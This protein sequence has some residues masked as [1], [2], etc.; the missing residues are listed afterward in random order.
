M[1][2]LMSRSTFLALLPVAL[3]LFAAATPTKADLIGSSVSG[4]MQVSGGTVNFFDPANGFVPAGFGNSS[5]PDN[6]VIGAE[7]EF[8]YM[9]GANTDTADF[10]GTSLTL[11]DVS[12]LGGSVPV[13]FIFTDTAFLG[14]TITQGTDSFP[15]LVTAD[16]TGDVLTLTMP[17]EAGNATWQ[18][19][20]TINL[21]VV[22][23]PEPGTLSLMLFGLG[24]LG[25]M[26]VMRKHIARSL[27]QAA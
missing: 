2:K 25:L 26:I 9:D 3:V 20:L 7:T 12:V 15:S 19:N 17:S 14:A 4:Q 13:T 10:T 22:Q 18:D 8:G 16:L 1:R 24:S 5:S 27:P 6:V 11:Q 23:T 21:V